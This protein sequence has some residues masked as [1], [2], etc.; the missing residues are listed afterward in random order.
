MKVSAAASLISLNLMAGTLLIHI[1]ICDWS[2]SKRYFGEKLYHHPNM[3]YKT[4]NSIFIP[5]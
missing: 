2:K 1:K 4:G 5:V 3:K